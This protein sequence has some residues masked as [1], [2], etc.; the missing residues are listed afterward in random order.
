VAPGTRLINVSA[1]GYDSHAETIEVT[2][3]P[4]EIVVRFREVRLSETVQ[5]VH[6]H[7]IGSCE[8]RLVADL[9]GIRYD[10]SNKGHVFSAPLAEVESIEVNYLDKNLRLKLRGGRTFNFTDKSPNADKLYVFQRNVEK[11]RTRLANGDPPAK[12]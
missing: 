2:P 1:P 3:G 11:A 10:T 9:D 12:R 4:R 8:G 7:G 6:K 5:V